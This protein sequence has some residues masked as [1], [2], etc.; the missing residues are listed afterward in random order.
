MLYPAIDLCGA[1][2]TTDCW[3]CGT[4]T[5]HTLT[6]WG[7]GTPVGLPPTTASSPQLTRMAPPPLTRDFSLSLSIVALPPC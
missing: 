4:P 7:C 5:P 2:P 6:G 3:G 1:P